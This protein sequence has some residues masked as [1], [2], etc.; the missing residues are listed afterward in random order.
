MNIIPS[1]NCI[2]C[3]EESP[4]SDSENGILSLP[5]HCKAFI[6]KKCFQKLNSHHCVIC[7]DPNHYSNSNLSLQKISVKFKEI[8][9]KVNS[10]PVEVHIDRNHRIS[11]CKFLILNVPVL[12]GYLCKIRNKVINNIKLFCKKT[13]NLQLYLG[14]LISDFLCIILIIILEVFIVSLLITIIYFIGFLVISTI[15]FIL[16]ISYDLY[17]H[18]GFVLLNIIIGCCCSIC[19]VIGKKRE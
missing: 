13:S 3:L 11:C 19:C 8:E 2:I 10:I 5:C 15:L 6:H 4:I 17:P 18:I 16:G 7:K 12:L 14:K 9:I 1:S